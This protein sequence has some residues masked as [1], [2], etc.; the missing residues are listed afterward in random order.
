MDDRSSYAPLTPLGEVMRCESVATVVGSH[1]TGAV[2][3]DRNTLPE[4]GQPCEG[5]IWKV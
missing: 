3:D 1:H 2:Q 5:T 4:E